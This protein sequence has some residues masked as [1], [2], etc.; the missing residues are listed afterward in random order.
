MRGELLAVVAI[1]L[2]FVALNVSTA[3]LYPPVTGDEALFADPAVNLATGNGFR[4]SVWYTQPYGSVFASNAPLYP[5]VL[6]LWMRLTGFTPVAVRALNYLLMAVAA[7]LLWF[8]VKRT[9]LIASAGNRLLF[10]CAILFGEGIAFAYRMGRYDALGLLIMSMIWAV[11]VAWPEPWPLRRTVFFLLGWLLLLSG[12]QC[13]VF[14]ILLGTLL[15]LSTDSRKVLAAGLPVGIG[16]A[17]GL[18][19]LYVIYHLAGSQEYFIGSLV[20][21]SKLRWTVSQR[22]VAA[23]M[24]VREDHSSLLVLLACAVLIFPSGRALRYGH[25]PVL[26]ALLVLV[27]L[28]ALMAFIWSFR[29]YYSW[30]KYVPGVVC[31]VTALDDRSVEG[32]QD[33]RTRLAR[34]LV[35][36]ACLGF[37]ARL[38]IAAVEHETWDYKNVERFVERNIREGEPAVVTLEAYYPAKRKACPLYSDLYMGF[39]KE[40]EKQAVRVIVCRPRRAESIIENLGGQWSLVATYAAPMS[41]SGSG[42]LGLRWGWPAYELDVYRRAYGS[43][44]SNHAGASPE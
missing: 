19:C 14:M 13:V 9:R 2:V 4:S 44:S 23:V 22:G 33:R 36:L 41:L 11:A 18:V 16:I 30:M 26:L 42:R 32:L 38:A 40:R 43:E 3:M 29:D 31:A 28:P 24:A 27:A 37:P 7:S 25:R 35:V 8:S 17:C 1:G 21:H 34:A 5:L 6:S 20:R 15:W 39:L 10:L 12:F